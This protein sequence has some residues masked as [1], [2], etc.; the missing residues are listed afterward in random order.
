MIIAYPITCNILQYFVCEN[1]WVNET[2]YFLLHSVDQDTY[3]LYLN[4]QVLT[5]IIG[6]KGEPL[7]QAVVKYFLPFWGS[8]SWENHT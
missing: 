3:V 5:K 7:N 2:E 6:V 8:D 4:F 1:Q